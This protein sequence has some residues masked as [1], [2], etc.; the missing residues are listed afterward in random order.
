MQNI[1]KISQKFIIFRT[2]RE[3][4]AT[5]EVKKLAILS[6]KTSTYC[7]RVLSTFP[8]RP[9][10]K[11]FRSLRRRDVWTFSKKKQCWQKCIVLVQ[12]NNFDVVFQKP[13]VSLDTF[14]ANEQKIF[15]KSSKKICASLLKLHSTRW[16]EKFHLKDFSES[17]IIYEF[18]SALGTKKFNRVRKSA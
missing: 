16:G 5:I 15:K 14:S 13:V 6:K 12:R 7:S 17:V 18:S 8:E 11:N 10:G 2:L 9:P 3:E 4:K 1:G